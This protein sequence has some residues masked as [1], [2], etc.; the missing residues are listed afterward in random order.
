MKV[1][2]LFDGMAFK[3]MLRQL[4]SKWGVMSTEMQM[5]YSSHIYHRATVAVTSKRIITI[6]HG[7]NFC[8]R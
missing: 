7:R 3:T 6:T 2:S 4:I 1:L 5:A 8:G